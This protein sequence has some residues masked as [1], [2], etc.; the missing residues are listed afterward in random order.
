[1]GCRGRGSFPFPCTRAEITPFGPRHDPQLVTVEARNGKRR[2]VD[3]I[4]S[5]VDGQQ[6]NIFPPSKFGSGTLPGSSSETSRGAGRAAPAARCRIPVPPR[7][8]DT[9]APMACTPHWESPS[10][11]LH[12]D[13]ARCTPAENDRTPAVAPLHA[14]LAAMP[15][16]ASACDACARAAR[17][18][19][20]VPP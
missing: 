2:E 11:A 13:A 19:P 17:F 1:M 9:L 10:P 20:D 12:A 18:V 16:P 14:P 6:A 7:A 8:P 3:G 5:I 4:E 15:F